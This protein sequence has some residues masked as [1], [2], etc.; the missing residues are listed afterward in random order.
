[1]RM[2]SS[3]LLL[4]IVFWLSL[5][6]FSHIFVVDNFT[7][8]TEITTLQ[9]LAD[10]KANYTQV[11]TTRKNCAP[12][13]IQ[14]SLHRGG[15][16][17]VENR[18]V[19]RRERLLVRCERQKDAQY[20]K[21]SKT[22]TQ[23]EYWPRG[24]HGHMMLDVNQKLAG[25]LVEK[26]GSSSWHKVF[27]VLREPEGKEFVPSK[28]YTWNYAAMKKIG[29]QTWREAMNDPEWIRF[30]TARHPLAR[31]YSGSDTNSFTSIIMNSKGWNR[32]LQRGGPMAARLVR[33]MRMGAYITQHDLDHMISWSDF[34]VYF[35]TAVRQFPQLINGHFH[36]IYDK[37]GLCFRYSR[38]TILTSLFK[39]K[40][41]NW[42]FKTI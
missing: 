26:A 19:H 21:R 3:S 16:W 24:A 7:A 4:I 27:W 32:N 30:V 13:P 40:C 15:A 1:M 28:S 9:Q 11:N 20:I 25:C 29:A 31:L 18:M 41:I 36:P 2:I 23:N 35:S 6:Y 14:R 38:S 42:L 34:I 8:F 17:Q 5:G 10:V 12:A 22:C 33:S 39:R 37:C